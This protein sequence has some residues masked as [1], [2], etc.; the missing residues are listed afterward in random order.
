ML[1]HFQKSHYESL[2]LTIKNFRNNKKSYSI[3]NII[4]NNKI[5]LQ[6]YPEQLKHIFN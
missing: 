5:T 1:S 3:K 2:I 6:N 4:A